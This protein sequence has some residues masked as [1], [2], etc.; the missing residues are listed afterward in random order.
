MHKVEL[1]SADFIQATKTW[2][3]LTMHYATSRK[4]RLKGK[5]LDVF[6]TSNICLF[7]FEIIASFYLSL[8]FHDSSPNSMLLSTAE[9]N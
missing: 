2:K 3:K 8:Y 4:L 5:G 6:E 1:S 7:E 9:Q